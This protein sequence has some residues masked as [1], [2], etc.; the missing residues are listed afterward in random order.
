MAPFA[1][2]CA[3]AGVRRQQLPRLLPPSIPRCQERTLS[4]SWTELPTQSLTQSLAVQVIYPSTTKA[5]PRLPKRSSL[6]QQVKG[7]RPEKQ[8]RNDGCRSKPD[9]ASWGRGECRTGNFDLR[10]HGSKPDGAS[11]GRGQGGTGNLDLSVHRSEP[12]G[13]SWG[14]RQGGAGNLDLSLHGSKPD[15]ASWR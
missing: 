10:F 13:A 7:T 15:G 14:R 3:E 2:S 1:R 12:D 11:W 5:H 8:L 4:T 9:R 6:Y